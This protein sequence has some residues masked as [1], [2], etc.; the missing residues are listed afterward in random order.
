MRTGAAR[1]STARVAEDAAVAA[2]GIEI[3]AAELARARTAYRGSL[4]SSRAWRA[5]TT[6]T[7]H[8]DVTYWT[9]LSSLF[10]EPGMNRMT[11][12]DRI[13]TYAGVSRSTAERAIREARESGYI[14][15]R[16]AGKEVQ[17]FLSP[18]TSKHC[19]EYFRNY[20]DFEKIIKTLG[21]SK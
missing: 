6:N 4:E 20:M 5:F 15:D 11:L 16:P 14:I 18:A 10:A 12:I 19:I 3:S 9:L 21:Y 2:E 1:R 17:H 13:I 8:H 7:R